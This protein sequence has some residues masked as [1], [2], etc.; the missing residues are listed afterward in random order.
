MPYYKV[1]EVDPKRSALIVVDMQNDFLL[2]DAPLEVEDGRAIIPR[3]KRAIDFCRERGIRVVYTV[4]VHRADG[5]DL[6]L[7]RHNSAIE[8]GAALRDDAPGAEVHRDIAPKAGET[9]I[10]KHRYSGFYGTDL[11]LVLRGAQIDTVIIAGTTTENCCHATA[12]DA[13]FRDF[14]VVFLADATATFD[15]GDDGLG[16]LSS[17]QVHRA[18]L[19]ILG[20]STADVMSVDEFVAR[21]QRENNSGFDAGVDEDR[22]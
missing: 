19:I 16:G 2:P 3:V 6:G 12:R 11:E 15:Y 8:S 13:M 17:E 1:G 22:R 20:Q 14:K 5:S 7:F 4:H 9:V 21:V 10:K 18:S